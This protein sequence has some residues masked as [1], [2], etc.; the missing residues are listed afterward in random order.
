MNTL[1]TILLAIVM[2]VIAPATL[3]SSEVKNSINHIDVEEVLFFIEDLPTL[4]SIKN[5]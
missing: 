1:V 2:E 4:I 5:C 3:S